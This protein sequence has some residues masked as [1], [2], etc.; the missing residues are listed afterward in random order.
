MPGE[1]KYQ[2]VKKKSPTFFGPV[3]KTGKPVKFHYGIPGFETL[4]DFTFEDL[5]DYPPFQLFRS[6]EEPELGMIVLNARYLK[7][8]KSVMIPKGE[9][10]KINAKHQRDIEIYVILRVKPQTKQFVANTK[11]PLIVNKRR[12]KGNQIILEN[13]DLQGEYPLKVANVSAEDE[14]NQ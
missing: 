1:V 2:Q 3:E 5:K 13:R 8:F 4:C 7:P 12:R 9:L 10:H 11:A 14:T 6:L